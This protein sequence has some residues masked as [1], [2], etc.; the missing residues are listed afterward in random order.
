MCVCVTTGSLLC[1]RLLGGRVSD[2]RR[3]GGSDGDGGGEVG[4][5]TDGYGAARSGS[6]VSEPGT[7]S[8]KCYREISN[9]NGCSSL[10]YKYS[11]KLI[12]GHDTNLV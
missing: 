2:G 10:K 4:Y 5:G 11:T 7:I 3:E 1:P 9:K 12:Q 6:P 8:V